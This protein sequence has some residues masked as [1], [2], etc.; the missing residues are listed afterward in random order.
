MEKMSCAK[1]MEFLPN[2][3]VLVM[4][5]LAMVT[6][7]LDNVKDLKS[8][9]KV[10]GKKQTHLVNTLNAEE[11]QF[12]VCVLQVDQKIAIRER[13]PIQFSVIQA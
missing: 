13:M 5:K 8:N 12:P 11:E 6:L 2:P 9:K 4:I 7:Q 1:R 3:V 10:S